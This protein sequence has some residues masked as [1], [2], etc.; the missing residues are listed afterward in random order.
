V[1]TFRALPPVEPP[2]APDTYVAKIIKAIEKI[3]EAG[4]SMLILRLQLPD[5]KTLPSV[6]T[7]VQRAE[8]VINA[9]CQSTELLRPTE[10]N[11]EVE[12]RPEH[13]LGRYVY[14]RLEHDQDG[15]PKIVRFIDRAAAL[16]ADPRLASVA[17]QPQAP[18]TLPVI[19]S[20]T[21]R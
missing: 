11:T 2:P 19:K 12:L 15:A 7:F 5:G 17:L 1:A 21:G 20:H 9:F 13:C 3:S 18:I 10:P 16:A 4:N 8:P 6:L 14:F